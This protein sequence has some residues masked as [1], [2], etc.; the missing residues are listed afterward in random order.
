MSSGNLSSAHT[1]ALALLAVHLGSVAAPAGAE[2]S[3]QGVAP[4]SAIE[5]AKEAAS[6]GPAPAILKRATE[7]KSELRQ[8]P[9]TGEIQLIGAPLR[10]QYGVAYAAHPRDIVF[11][12]EVD[13]D[14]VYDATALP[15]D[16]KPET[17]I[18]MLQLALEREFGFGVVREMRRSRVAVL[19]RMK[20][21]IVLEP[22]SSK[23][24]SLEQKK[25]SFRATGTTI[26]PLVTFLRSLSEVPVVERTGL[27]E[28]Y[29]LVLEWDPKGGARALR[30][31]LNDIGLEIVF[32]VRPYPF[33]L[34]RGPS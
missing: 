31:A 13:E 15:A 26:A 21:G 19:Q 1:L 18:R 8:N 2:E 9:A 22:S 4:R 33:L 24:F 12:A 23:T 28:R 16:G 20:G 32:E 14:A 17:A 27:F 30:Q 11:E 29:D 5:V 6:S 3:T 7:R 10:T 34:V 25:G